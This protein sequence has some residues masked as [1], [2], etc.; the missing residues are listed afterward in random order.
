MLKFIYI[1]LGMAVTPFVMEYIN[2][3][4]TNR[5]KVKNYIKGWPAYAV[6]VIACFAVA[7]IVC[8]LPGGWPF[9]FWTIAILLT[10]IYFGNQFFF[11]TA[12]KPFAHY[13]DK[14]RF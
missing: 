1:V 2:M 9:D 10:V 14:L 5:D 11:N 6:N 4:V 8:L 13:R 12:I 3:N 7:F